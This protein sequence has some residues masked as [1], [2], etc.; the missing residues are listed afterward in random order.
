MTVYEQISCTCL[1]TNEGRKSK[2]KGFCVQYAS[3]FSELF[4][5][6]KSAHY[7]RKNTVCCHGNKIG[8]LWYCGVY[9][10][11]SCCICKKPSTI[12]NVQ[13]KCLGVEKIVQTGVGR[14]KENFKAIKRKR[15]SWK[16]N[17]EKKGISHI[18]KT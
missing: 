1:R 18:A 3:K 6:E 12:I 11:E 7:T 5:V 17:L 4:S 14:V 16:L 13:G 15:P 9:I 10:V 8:R 2:N